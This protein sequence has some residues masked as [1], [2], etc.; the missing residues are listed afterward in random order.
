MTKWHR[1]GGD[2]VGSVCALSQDNEIT[3]KC[4]LLLNN[5]R[6]VCIHQTPNYHTSC[7]KLLELLSN[8]VTTCT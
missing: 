3:R 4:M 7:D 2:T 6:I 5:N 1:A 8:S